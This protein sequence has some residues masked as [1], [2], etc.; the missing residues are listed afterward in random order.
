[1]MLRSIE[2]NHYLVGS[3]ISACVT[4]GLLV[5]AKI[6]DMEPAA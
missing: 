6:K 4:F 1:M 5:G 3:A 2:G